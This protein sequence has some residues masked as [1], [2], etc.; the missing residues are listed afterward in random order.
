MEGAA[1]IS[2]DVSVAV[3]QQQPHQ[4]SS[5]YSSGG[6]EQL[7]GGS[8]GGGATVPGCVPASSA[9]APGESAGAGAPR[10]LVIL[11]LPYFTTDETLLAFFSQYG[12]VEEALVMR[13]H[14]SGRSRGF[15]FVT[16]VAPEDAARAAGREYNVDGRRC[17]AKFALPRGESAAQRVTRI[18]V[19]KLPP[20]VTEDELRIYFEQVGARGRCM[21]NCLRHLY[22]CPARS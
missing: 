6:S 18:F 14:A 1:H 16:F 15:G 2:G 12:E 3:Q 10:K 20:N 11:G 13:D 5:E 7:T 8:M 9:G 4:H 21:G 22:I 19:A 17:E